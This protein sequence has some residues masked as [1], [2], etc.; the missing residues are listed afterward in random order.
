M[1]LQIGTK[2]EITCDGIK[3][4]AEVVD[5]QDNLVEFK[6]EGDEKTLFMELVQTAAGTYRLRPRTKVAEHYIL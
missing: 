2:V 1:H 3:T 5:I 6:I 4:K